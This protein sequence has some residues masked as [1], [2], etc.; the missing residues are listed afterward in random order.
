MWVRVPP[1]ARSRFPGRLFHARSGRPIFA[2]MSEFILEAP[3]QVLGQN[4]RIGKGTRILAESVE[5]GDGVQ[6]GDG[7]EI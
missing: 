6:I 1:P 4:V 7:V 5:L 2:A 3:Q